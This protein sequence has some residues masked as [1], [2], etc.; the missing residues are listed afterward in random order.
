MDGGHLKVHEPVVVNTLSYHTQ[1]QWAPQFINFWSSF[2]AHQ[3]RSKCLFYTSKAV[4]RLG[5]LTDKFT[6]LPRYIVKY[7]LDV[8]C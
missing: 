5:R 3:E 1:C 4:L 7:M 6:M 2:G 8:N